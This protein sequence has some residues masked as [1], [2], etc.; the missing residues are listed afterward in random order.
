MEECLIICAL[1]DPPPGALPAWGGLA[2]CAEEHGLSCFRP[3]EDCLRPL[4]AGVLWGRFKGPD[5]AL[6]AFDLA[7]EAASDLLGYPVAVSLRLIRWTSPPRLALGR[8]G[9]WEGE[10]PARTQLQSGA[11]G[12]A[13]RP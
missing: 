6:Q 11:G 3:H 12:Q 13:L 2:D 1:G 5:E 8:R 9:F 7:V 4:P 10:D